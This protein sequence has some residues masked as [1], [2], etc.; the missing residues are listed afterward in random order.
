MNFD[1][2]LFEFSA[3]I[4]GVALLGTVFLYARQPIIIAYIA[5]GIIIG[6]GGLGLIKRPES[7]EQMAHLGVV[8][9]LFIIGLNLK[10]AKLIKLFSKA[11]WG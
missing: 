10:P 4:V 2:I 5:I 9:L 7:V 1:S 3:I 6:P 11:V 8:L